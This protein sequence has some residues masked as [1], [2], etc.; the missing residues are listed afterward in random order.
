[1]TLE[2]Q[3]K[4]Y[5]GKYRSKHKES[6]DLKKGTKFY[7]QNKIFKTDAKNLYCEQP[8]RKSKNLLL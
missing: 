8:I 6:E 1:M 2:R 5:N 3:K 7:R 4:E